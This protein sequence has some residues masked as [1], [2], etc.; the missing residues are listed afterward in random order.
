MIRVIIWFK[1]FLVV[2]ASC[3]Q[4]RTPCLTPKI[5]VMNVECVHLLTDTSTVPVD[6]ALTNAIFASETQYG[7]NGVLY[8]QQSTFVLSLSSLADSATWLF[9]TDSALHQ[10]DTLSFFYTRDLHFLSNACGYA[11]FYNLDSFHT[12][13]NFIDS[14]KIKTASVTDNVKPTH[15]K[16]YIHPDY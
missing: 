10:F 16:I 2:L 15:F 6:T 1:G 7:I 9:T 8:P 11:Y 3:T 5:A 4:E 14:A 12:T 13:H